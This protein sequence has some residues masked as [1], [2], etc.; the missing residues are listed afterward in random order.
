MQNVKCK[1]QNA[2]RQ[3]RRQVVGLAF[4]VRFAF[5]ILSFALQKAHGHVFD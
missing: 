5:C 4:D 3:K 2:K 1:M